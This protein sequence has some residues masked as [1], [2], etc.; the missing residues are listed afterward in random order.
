[1]MGAFLV[2]ALPGAAIKPWVIAWL[3]F[4][5][6]LILWRAWR[7]APPTV[8]SFHRKGILGFVGGFLDAIGGGG[9]GPTV[10][11][12]LVGSGVPPRYAVGTTNTAEFFVAVTTTAAFA[13]ALMTGH[14]VETPRMETHIWAVAGLMTG[15]VAA[16]PIAGWI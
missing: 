3:L 1:L 15:G 4:M 9:W 16:A 14:W 13:T 5:G 12:T 7:G 2:T 11:T 6:L 8:R 10:T